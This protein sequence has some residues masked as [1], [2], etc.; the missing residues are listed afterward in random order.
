MGN[1]NN[2][3]LMVNRMKKS[4][5]LALA[6]FSILVVSAIP[7]YFYTRPAQVQEGTVQIKGQVKNPLTI[8]FS[9][10]EN[11]TP[12]TLEVTLSSS[13]RIS[14]NGVFNYTGVTLRTLLE[15]ANGSANATSVYIQASDGYGTTIPIQDAMNQNTI[16]AYQKNGSPLTELKD[17]GEGP[18]RLIIGSDQYAQRWIRGVVAIEA[19]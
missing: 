18:L 2:R 12:R 15:Q 9:Q 19:S 4:T 5:K 6:L 11:Y 17:D 13:S 3:I 10:L 14:D 7:L 16:I 1:T 8:T